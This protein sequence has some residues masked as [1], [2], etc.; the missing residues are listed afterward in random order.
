MELESDEVARQLLKLDK[1]LLF[2]KDQTG[3]GLLAS[4]VS[5]WRLHNWFPHKASPGVKL[6]IQNGADLHSVGMNAMTPTAEALSSSMSFLKWRK[7]LV[8]CGIDLERF[9]V[10][11]EITPHGIHHDSLFDLGWA[12]E[13][14]L[15]LFESDI[16]FKGF[17]DELRCHR[18]GLDVLHDGY[19][20][21]ARELWWHE[22][23][24]RMMVGDIRGAMKISVESTPWRNM[25]PNS[26]SPDASDPA[27]HEFH[28]KGEG[29]HKR[30]LVEPKIRQLWAED[31][32]AVRYLGS[33][34]YRASDSYGAS[35]EDTS[36]RYRRHI[37]FP[38]R[39]RQRYKRYNENPYCA[40]CAPPTQNLSEELHETEDEDEE[41]ERTDDEED[42]AFLL[43][44]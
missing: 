11:E 17:D 12:R 7:C 41:D 15:N 40:E 43:S 31:E 30:R 26:N 8:E 38:K 24:E 32:E 6:V 34:G 5:Q 18:C 28:V 35:V 14:L 44:F 36:T 27:N 23:V 16:K 22:F 39:L 1:T 42:S 33:S 4:A 25:A 9:V 21:G 3:S 2:I 19:S 37:I 13:S 29:K 20:T 10:E